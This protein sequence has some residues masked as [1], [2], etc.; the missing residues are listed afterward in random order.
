MHANL[1]VYV[2]FFVETF[3]MTAPISYRIPPAHAEQFHDLAT[4]N[5]TTPARLLT[6]FIQ[7]VLER[8]ENFFPFLALAPLRRAEVKAIAARTALD[9][10]GAPPLTEAQVKLMLHNFGA[11][12]AATFAK[13]RPKLVDAAG[14]FVESRVVKMVRALAEEKWND[15]SRVKTATTTPPHQIIGKRFGYIMVLSV[16]D[17][18]NPPDDAGFI[19]TMRTSYAWALCRCD[20]GNLF[21]HAVPSLHKARCGGHKTPRGTH[22]YEPNIEHTCPLLPKKLSPMVGRTYGHL[23]ITAKSHLRGKWIC[24]C[25]CGTVTHVAATSLYSGNTKSCGCW[26]TARMSVGLPR[27]FESTTTD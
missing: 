23:T 26:R 27:T 6:S 19:Q 24:T 16:V 5:G 13:Y 3:L 25:R 10:T 20:C 21:Y 1:L 7:G 22:H 11:K 2:L 12:G 14:Q 15:R 9:L 17:N 8:P 4:A 18:S